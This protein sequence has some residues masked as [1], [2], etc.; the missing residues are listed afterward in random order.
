MLSELKNV[1]QVEGEPF[2]RWFHDE[3]FDLIVWFGDADEI[4]EFQLCYDLSGYE[5]ALTWKKDSGFLHE[6]VDQG[7]DRPGQA[8]ATPI[9]VKDGIF[10]RNEIAERFKDDSLEIDSTIS[11]FIYDRLMEFPV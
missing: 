8:K 6:Q 9:L 4:L 1:R 3:F 10:N 2:R 7:E 5:R 11:E